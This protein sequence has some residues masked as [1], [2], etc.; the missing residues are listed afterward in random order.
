MARTPKTEGSANTAAAPR[1]P[2]GPLTVFAILREGADKQA[3]KASIAKVTTNK[4]ELFKLLSNE[5][6]GASFISFTVERG[7]RGG[8]DDVSV[9]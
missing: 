5:D 8:Q 4:A 9:D 6:A 7:K 2:A 3:I 1:R